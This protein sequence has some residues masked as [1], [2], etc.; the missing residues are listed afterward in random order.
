MIAAILAG[1]LIIGPSGNTFVQ[2]MGI[3]GYNVWSSD[4]L[5]QVR[6]FQ[7]WQEVVRPDGSTTKVIDLGDDIRIEPLIP[8]EVGGDGGGE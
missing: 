1:A 5:T 6:D 4:G 7:R 3:N 2:P 8:V